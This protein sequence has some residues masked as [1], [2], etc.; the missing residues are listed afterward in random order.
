MKISLGNRSIQTQDIHGVFDLVHG[1]ASEIKERVGTEVGD[2][3]WKR[4]AHVSITITASE[5]RQILELAGM[6]TGK[7]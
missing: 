2:S 3:S 5:A 6:Y 1:I 4:D 7:D